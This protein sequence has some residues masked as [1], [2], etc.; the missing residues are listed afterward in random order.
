[1]QSQMIQLVEQKL[2][3]YFYFCLNNK[4]KNWSS[5]VFFYVTQDIVL[6]IMINNSLKKS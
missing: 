1:M 4:L 2:K 3:M 5:S 6:K